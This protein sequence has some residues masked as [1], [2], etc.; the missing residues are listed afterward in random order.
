MA[1]SGGRSGE[2]P[3]GLSF[4]APGQTKLSENDLGDVRF[5]VAAAARDVAQLKRKV[6]SWRDSSSLSVEVRQDPGDRR[7]IEHVLISS[8][9]FP[10]REWSMHAGR[11]INEA[12][13]ALDN[14]NTLMFER[15]AQDSYDPDGIYFPITK[16]GK[17]WRS[18]RQKHRALP[19]WA[20]ERYKKIQPSQGPF[21]G[22]LGLQ[23]MD[24]DRKHKRL[25]P[26]NIAILGE[27]S[28]WT[29]KVEGL[30]T[31]NEPEPEIEALSNL[32]GPGMRSIKIARIRF[33]R[34]VLEIED[35]VEENGPDFDLHFSF[36]DET[37]ELP[38]LT[39][40]PRRVSDAID[41]V[42]SGDGAALARYTARPTFLDQKESAQPFSQTLPNARA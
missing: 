41:Y 23:A 16:D 9:T 42:S 26:L 20:I 6:A 15:F 10:H 11:A 40:L 7:V 38:E 29:A 1:T 31:E 18:W 27:L 33:A 12:R 13:S 21:K 34:D 2:A 28:R 4:R 19:E 37:Y 36:H 35:Q 32:L 25:T 30:V 17:E 5:R 8:K 3:Q 14:F 22:L 24:N 39:D